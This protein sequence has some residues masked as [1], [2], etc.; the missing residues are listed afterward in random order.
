MTGG[1]RRILR[2]PGQSAPPPPPPIDGVEKAIEWAR[3]VV[4]GDWRACLLVVQA[5]TNFLHDLDEAAAG[6]GR[7]EFRR[8]TAEASM[9]FCEQMRNVKGPM[10]GQPLQLMGWQRMVMTAMFGFY[11]KAR[12]TRRYKQAVI[13]IPKGNGKSSWMAAVAL[14]V[15]FCEGEG[16]AEGY[17]AAVTREQAR[18]VFD[19]AQQM[20]VKSPGFR[21]AYGVDVKANAIFQ[22]ASASRLIPISSDAKSLDGL[23]V[24]IGICDEV[25][26]HKTAEVYDV[27]FTATAKRRHPMLI[28]ISTASS[29]AHGIGK[30]LW[31]MAVRVT[32]NP[33]E[34][35]SL[36]PLI[37]TTD[38]GD[39]PWLESTWIKANPGWGISVQ[40]EAIHGIM[41]QARSNPAQE[42]VAMT[43][44]LNIW[45]GADE[46]LFSM[47]SWHAC[48]NADLRLDDFKG[49]DC[50]IGLDLAS[51]ID[52]AAKVLVFPT[53]DKASGQLSY[54][55]FT[56]CYLNE[57]AVLQ[58]RNPSYPGWAKDNH[59]L[60]T[61]GNE[62][63]F[64]VI[65]EELIADAKLYKVRE[66]AYDPWAATQLAQRLSSIRLP[67]IEFPANT[68][69]F[70]EPTKELDAAMHG[71][72]LEHD[73]NP[74]MAW[75]IGNVV[76][77]FDA[78]GNVY[79]KKERVENKIDAAIA[80]IMCIGRA[81]VGRPK[82]SIYE[83]QKGLTFV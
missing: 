7:W 18:I 34:N 54:A 6:R 61:D 67:V 75:C 53:Y 44:H 59:L 50:I 42:A 2:R 23:N 15:T 80:L 9:L 48:K 40:A 66:I 78:R 56:R 57:E 37:F 35:S 68:R 45:A 79:P 46:A 82:R 13:Y 49:R 28:S 81:M 22:M 52:L 25:A 77:R 32:E 30:Q 73:G 21:E 24:H 10:A 38:D 64:S 17:T 71:M 1:V 16:G 65:E 20:T 43:R 31:N 70:S 55:V 69:N 3:E 8:S 72:R 62:T 83:D 63:D 36:F 11:D 19:M 29:N 4:S 74:V 12:D 60:I 5:C 76:G 41:R 27:L 33:E 47:R 39:D 51:K 58:A 14:Y 26:S